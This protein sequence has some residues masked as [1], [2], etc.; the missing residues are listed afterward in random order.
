MGQSV[1]LWEW[2]LQVRLNIHPETNL[3]FMEVLLLI[4]IS[5]GVPTKYACLHRV[6]G[7]LQ[8]LINQAS[9]KA[10]RLTLH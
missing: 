3:P 9:F 2:L 7:I 5:L 1:S 6:V 4:S 10:F 8:Q